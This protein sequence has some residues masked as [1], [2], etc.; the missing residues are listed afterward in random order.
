M[1]RLERPTICACCTQTTDRTDSMV[2]HMHRHHADK[3]QYVGYNELTGYTFTPVGDDYPHIVMA[4]HPTRQ[5]IGYCTQC[6]TGFHGPAH[7]KNPV[8]LAK[9]FKTHTCA[10][11]QV[12]TRK[13]TVTTEDGSGNVTVKKETQTGGY[14][15][16]EEML[17]GW[18]K[19]YPRIEI[20]L[21]DN[22]DYDIESTVRKA[23][24]D[25][26]MLDTVRSQQKQAPAAEVAPAAVS[27]DIYLQ[28]MQSFVSDSKI[29]AMMAADIKAEQDKALDIDEDDSDAE[30]QEADYRKALRSRILRA[31]TLQT[32][33]DKMAADATQFQNKC[34]ELEDAADRERAHVARL[35]LELQQ[36]RM[37]AARREQEQAEEIRQLRAALQQYKSQEVIR[38][39]A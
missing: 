39:E 8:T 15:V 35:Q 17:S 7:V 31:V 3:S 32:K 29:G 37:A 19:Q 25:S 38:H 36:E 12:R 13:V 27:G 4:T 1:T 9:H 33:L 20:K 6:F 10:E 23:I 28:V 16:T 5:A 30:L 11:K 21:N 14:T 2:R 26:H 22:L 24:V 34:D 18:K